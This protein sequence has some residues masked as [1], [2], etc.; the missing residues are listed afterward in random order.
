[1]ANSAAVPTHRSTARIVIGLLTTWPI[2]FT[3]FNAGEK[4]VDIILCDTLLLMFLVVPLR[5]NASRPDVKSLLN[6]GVF[7]RVL[8]A[9]MMTY[10]VSLALVVFGSTQE[11]GRVLAS[12]KFAKPF[13]FI[14]LGRQ[15]AFAYGLIPLFRAIATGGS[16]VVFL[17]FVSTVTAPNFPNV[18][19]GRTIFEWSVYGY[20]NSAMTFFAALVPLLLAAADLAIKPWHVNWFRG[21]AAIAGLLTVA[22][23]SRSSTAVLFLGTAVYLT[24]TKRIRTPIMIGIVSLIIGIGGLVVDKQFFSGRIVDRLTEM[25]EARVHRTVSTNDPLSGRGEIWDHALELIA[26]RPVFGYAFEPFSNYSEGH[27]TPHQQY[28]EILYKTGSVGLVLFATL[29]LVIV[30]DLWKRLGQKELL[31]RRRYVIMAVLACVLAVLVG[32][33][34]Q[35]NLTYSL[36]GNGLFLFVGLT[37]IAAAEAAAGRRIPAPAKPARHR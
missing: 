5:L 23:M 21:S 18:L 10:C 8:A 35:P 20:P 1:M 36:T 16:I 7:A 6:D 12:I 29:M 32:N 28:L 37:S 14:F 25:I 26:D 22:S 17:M 13:L 24:L 34:T 3:V 27:G 2:A 19:W 15:L 31:G 9:L 11:M 30:F 33:L 4:P